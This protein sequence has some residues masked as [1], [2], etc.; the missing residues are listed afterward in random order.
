MRIIRNTILACLLAFGGEAQAVGMGFGQAEALGMAGAY[1]ASASGIH[2]PFW[3]PANLAAF[4][5]PTVELGIFN[6]GILV[7]NDGIKWGDIVD[8]TADD[9]LSIDE[10]KQS[11]DQFPGNSVSVHQNLEFGVPFSLTIG[12]YAVSMSFVEMIEVGLSRGLID[13]ISDDPSPDFSDEQAILDRYEQSKNGEVVRDLSGMKTDIWGLATVGFSYARLVDIPTL[14]L[15]AVGG[16]INLYGAT[17]RLR[18]VES[19]GQTIVRPNSWD[20]DATLVMELAGAQILRSTDEFG[21]KETDFSYDS[22]GGWGLGF[23]LGVAGRWDYDIDFSV[24]LHNIPLRKITWSSA[25]RRTFRVRNDNPVNAQTLFDGTPDKLDEFGNPVFDRFGD[26]EKQNTLDYLDTLLA[27]A[28]EK[29]ANTELL[30]SVT[31]A[32]PSY[33]RAGVKKDFLGRLVTV[34]VDIEQGFNETA[35]SSTTPRMAVGTVLRPLGNWIPI[36]AGMSIGGRTGHF[37]TLGTGLH[38]G[39]FHLDFSLMKEG[40]FTPFEVPFA[41]FSTGVGF[42][43]EMKLSF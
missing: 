22:F 21:E 42:A 6:T 27:P 15:F 2:A 39:F 11:L 10:I 28:G 40:A 23:N 18:I 7:G 25:E 12:H 35:I 37:A 5:G 30:S 36:R 43:L 32:P 24:A 8:W 19:S 17:P 20:T 9:V 14:D 41:G 31:A 3:N 34:G 16:T 26:P 33:L 29:V 4:P 13:M 1:T 38:A